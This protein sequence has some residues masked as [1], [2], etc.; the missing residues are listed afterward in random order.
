MNNI[1]TDSLDSLTYFFLFY[2]DGRGV[3]PGRCVCEFVTYITNLDLLL[4]DPDSELDEQKTEVRKAVGLALEDYMSYQRMSHADVLRLKQYIRKF[5]DDEMI[6]TEK[7][8]GWYSDLID[9]V[10]ASVQIG[11][12]WWKNA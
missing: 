11:K 6:V 10:Y 3:F 9:D 12:V 8:I 4:C 5:C 1:W 2:A 7:V